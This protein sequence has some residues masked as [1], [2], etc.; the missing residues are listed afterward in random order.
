MMILS[1]M[2]FLKLSMKILDEN[3]HENEHVNTLENSEHVI[4]NPEVPVSNL[5]DYFLT[6]DIGK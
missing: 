4:D 5:Q 3:F 2:M 6:G 1:M